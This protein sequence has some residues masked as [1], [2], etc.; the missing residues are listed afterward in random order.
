ML[1]PRVLTAIVLLALLLPALFHSPLAWGVAALVFVAVAAWEW[2]VLLERRRAAWPV[3]LAMAA[4]GAAVLAWRMDLLPAW[5]PLAGMA[6]PTSL[7][8]A[9]GVAAALY[10]LLL[11]PWRL[12][13]MD[14]R[15]GGLAFALLPLACAWLAMLELRAEGTWLLLS[16]LA[17]VWLADVGAYF[18]G[19]AVGRRKI[20]PRISPGKS[21]EGALGAAVLVVAVGLVVAHWA[22]GVRTLPGLLVQGLGVPLAALVLAGLSALSVVG[23]L[24]ESLLKRQAGVKDSGRTLP[25]HGGVLDRIDALLPVLPLAMLAARLLP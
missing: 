25:G 1:L 16:S 9:A 13:R 19:K 8:L 15:G 14:V 20:A 11:A 12:S 10:W 2:S 21:L 17:L 7:P 3:A 6:Y 24:H 23:D 22:P 4:G 5:F 18:V